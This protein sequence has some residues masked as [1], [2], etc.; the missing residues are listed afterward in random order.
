MALVCVVFLFHIRS[1]IVAIITLP[2][3]ILT[4]FVV[5]Y[6][7]GINANTVACGI[8]IAIGAMTDGAIVMTEN[9]HKHMENP[10][11]R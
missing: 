6:W 2:M 5:M 11:D 9:M 3:G 4:A 7:Q 10:S 1:S 8:A